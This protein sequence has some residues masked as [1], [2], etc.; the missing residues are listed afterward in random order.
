MRKESSQL[1]IFL[2]LSLPTCAENQE[3]KLDRYLGRIISIGND[4]TN[5]YLT[6]ISA[7]KQ[8]YFEV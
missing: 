5:L 4:I 1:A 2:Y 8:G 3:P 6:I 7:E